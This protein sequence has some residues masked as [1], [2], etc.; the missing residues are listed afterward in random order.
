MAHVKYITH[1]ATGWDMECRDLETPDFEGTNLVSESSVDRLGCQEK[2]RL[3]PA[4]NAVAW[5][6]AEKLC[7]MKE[8]FDLGMVTDWPVSADFDFCWEVSGGP[9]HMDIYKQ[10]VVRGNS[11]WLFCH[12]GSTLKP[13][14]VV[15]QCY[16]LS[17]WALE[18][19]QNILFVYFQVELC[20]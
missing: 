7:H 15:G 9:M 17:G 14:D 16:A 13:L 20:T 19:W 5:S 18:L 2:C 6:R 12:S 8:G 3:N 10:C 1:F 11:N 4:C